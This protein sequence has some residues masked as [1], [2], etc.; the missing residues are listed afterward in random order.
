MQ[1]TRFRIGTIA[2]GAM[3][4]S[5]L[6][7]LLGFGV[8][9]SAALGDEQASSAP[10]QLKTSQACL[11][12][13][14][15]GRVALKPNDAACPAPAPFQTPLW[16][17]TLSEGTDAFRPGPSLTPEISGTVGRDAPDRPRVDSVTCLG[18]AIIKRLVRSE[19]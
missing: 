16:L 10:I 19:E 7:L 5:V 12:V 2:L 1:F 4:G 18:E 8:T 11:L 13:D 14:G 3:L 15:E 6:A 17:I 9:G